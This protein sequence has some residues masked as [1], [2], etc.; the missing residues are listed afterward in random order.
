MRALLL[1]AL[2]A[3]LAL[4]QPE[5]VDWLSVTIAPF[6]APVRPLQQPVTA[7]VTTRASCLLADQ[8]AGGQVQ[9]QHAVKEKPAWATV[10]VSPATDVASV[11]GCSEGYLT[12]QATLTVTATDQAPAFAAA[13]IVVEATAGPADRQQVETAQVNLSAAYF[14]ILDVQ[15]SDPQIVMRPGSTHDA[16]VKVSNF[17]NGDT[18]VET[19]LVDAGEGLSVQLPPPVTLGSRQR[20]S[21]DTSADLV[22]RI[23]AADAAGVVNRVGVVNLRLTGSYATDPSEGVDDSAVS[24]L[25]S[26]RSLGG[27]GAQKLPGA[28][29]GALVALAFASA[30]RRA[31]RP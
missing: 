10:L 6:E 8:G 2:L 21:A 26:V 4:G 14:A 13:P 22:V 24:L 16:V 5:V 15:V 30:A 3:P 9:V 25:V 19:L 27:E 11:Q 31:L 18:R 23:L 17:G 7:Q 12:F 28:P 20:G 1:V 29:L